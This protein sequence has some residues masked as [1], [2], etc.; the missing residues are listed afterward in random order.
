MTRFLVRN[1]QKLRLVLI[2]DVVDAA[3]EA[4]IAR[5]RRDMYLKGCWS[6]IVVDQDEMVVLLNTFSSLEESAIEE[7]FRLTT[8]DLLSGTG[9]L[10][11]QV[12]IWLDRVRSN[13]HAALPHQES[14]AKLL[15]DVVPALAA[16]EIDRVEP[17]AA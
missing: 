7:D 9:T 15:Y 4:A 3:D 10:P 8:R 17:T 14:A 12:E 16:S 6:G 11:H 13:W 1:P 2:V 5:T